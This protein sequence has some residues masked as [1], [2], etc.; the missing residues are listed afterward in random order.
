MNQTFQVNTKYM[1]FDQE[2]RCQVIIKVTKRTAKFITYEIE[3][4]PDKIETQRTK[5]RIIEDEETL[6]L[7]KYQQP[8]VRIPGAY[9][10]LENVE[11]SPFNVVI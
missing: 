9:R 4:F 6:P 5:I 8:T 1:Y 7:G 2:S 10:G 11:F 3:T